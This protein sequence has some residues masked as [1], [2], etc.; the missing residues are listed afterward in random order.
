MIRT[1]IF[2]LALIMAIG[3]IGTTTFTQSAAAA[4]AQAGTQGKMK[5][6]TKVP[7]QAPKQAPKSPTYERGY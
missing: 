2:A 7:K 4:F 1:A 5:V 6:K 3:V